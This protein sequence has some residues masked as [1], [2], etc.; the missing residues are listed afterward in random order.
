MSVTSCYVKEQC[1]EQPYSGGYAR[2]INEINARFKAM[3]N[4]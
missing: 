4:F 3:D 2:D 1:K